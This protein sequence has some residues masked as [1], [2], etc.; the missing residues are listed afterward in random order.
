[1]LQL[2]QEFKITE[3]IISADRLDDTY[4]IQTYI[5]ELSLFEDLDKPYDTGQIVFMDDLGLIQ[6]I[7]IL[8]TEKIKLTGEF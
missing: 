7:K 6:E 2:A 4:D 3:A 5:I 1:M 8:G